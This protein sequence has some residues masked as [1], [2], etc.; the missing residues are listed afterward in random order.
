MALALG[1][2]RFERGLIHATARCFVALIFAKE[3]R[4][5]E[6]MRLLN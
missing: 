6:R 2:D 5:S 4:V 3:T 1:I